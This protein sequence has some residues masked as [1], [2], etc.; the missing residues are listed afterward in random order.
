MVQP[1]YPQ[2]VVVS[3]LDGFTETLATWLK[4]DQHRGKR[5]R[6]TIKLMYEAL[7]EQGYTGG[8]G[9]VAAF[10]RRWRESSRAR[11]ARAPS[12]R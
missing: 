11:P 12:C 9:R 5:D 8:Y 1:K 6:R 7:T 10:A 3:K 4:A 2:R